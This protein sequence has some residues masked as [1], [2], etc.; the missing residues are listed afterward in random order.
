MKGGSYTNG[1]KTFATARKM[2]HL[3]TIRENGK[4]V[5]GGYISY[6]W[7]I[8]TKLESYKTGNFAHIPVVNNCAKSTPAFL[9]FARNLLGAS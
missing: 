4:I 5:G 2:G 9:D 7:S 8:G 1:Y 6:S 3:K